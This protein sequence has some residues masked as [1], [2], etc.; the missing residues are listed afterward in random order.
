MHLLRRCPDL[1][2]CLCLRCLSRAGGALAQ[3][4]L[5]ALA[6]QYMQGF[7][8]QAAAA[9]AQA[10]VHAAQ[11]QQPALMALT[12]PGVAA[13]GG[14]VSGHCVL[15]NGRWWSPSRP[16]LVPQAGFLADLGPASVRVQAGVP[17][18]APMANVLGPFTADG[19]ARKLPWVVTK[20]QQ[21]SSS[22]R[23]AAPYEV[24]SQV[25]T[26]RCGS[27]RRRLLSGGLLGLVAKLPISSRRLTPH[28]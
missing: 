24:R 27:R 13:A 2:P 21:A 14:M 3:A 16:F 22:A 4:A 18:A 8:Q 26:G 15:R 7:A 17:A 5:Q 1:A 20:L 10:A 6:A 23:A 28:T 25:D 11:Q 19:L 9:Q 12:H